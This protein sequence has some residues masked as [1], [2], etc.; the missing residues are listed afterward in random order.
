MIGRFTK[1]RQRKFIFQMIVWSVGLFLIVPTAMIVFPY[2]IDMPFEK[3]GSSPLELFKGGGA[4]VG[5]GIIW[6]MGVAASLLAHI[7]NPLKE[8]ERDDLD[9][10]NKKEGVE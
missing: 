7:L 9:K 2:I 6:F 5:I 4:F 10:K 8:K 3:W 1:E